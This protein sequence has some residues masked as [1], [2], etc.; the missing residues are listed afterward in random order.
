MG[1]TS[2]RGYFVASGHYRDGILLSPITAQVMTRVVLGRE[3]QVDIS[4]F[5]ASR[6][7]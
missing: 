6:F 5:A 3:P 1:E 4:S 2:V 7:G